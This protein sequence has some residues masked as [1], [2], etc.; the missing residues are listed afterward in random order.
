MAFRYFNTSDISAYR[1]A[2]QVA[3]E[4][5]LFESHNISK[6]SASYSTKKSVFLS[7]SSSDKAAL[8]AVILF[9]ESFGVNVYIDK[10]DQSL[11]QQTSPETG[12]KLKERIHQCDKFIVLV[13]EN[14]KDSRWIPWE[15]GIADESKTIS[16]VALLPKVNHS[17]KPD[18]V[19][20]EYMGLYHRITH[21]GL[22][23]YSQSVWMVYDQSKNQAVE[24]KKWLNQ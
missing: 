22:E 24:L 4:Q 3:N 10:T 2:M 12:A 15:L 19:Q 9:L 18:W 21:G 8:P 13:S 11:P 6:K 7:H 5:A 17:E 1:T 14:S 16:N 20:Q 23:G